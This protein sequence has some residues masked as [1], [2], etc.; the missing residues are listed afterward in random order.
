MIRR[1][2]SARSGRATTYSETGPYLPATMLSIRELFLKVKLDPQMA[3]EDWRKL[4]E[5]SRFRQAVGQIVRMVRGERVGINMMDIAVCGAIAPYN[6]L[7]GGKL[8]CLL[9]CGP[10][11]IKE[12]RARYG[13][14]TSLIASCMRGASVKRVADLVLLCTTSLYGSALSQYSR[15][16]VPTAL[17]GGKPG[18]KVEFDCVGLSEGFG[19]FHFSKD[20]LRMMGMLL[21][22]S[23]EARKVNSIFGEGVNPLMRKIREG[24]G[25]LGLPADVLLKHGSKRVVYG[26]A[27]ARNFQ[28]YLLGMSD[29]PRYLIP[30]TRE[31]HRTALLA[32]YW[33]QRWLLKRIEKPGVLDEVARHTCVYPIRH[34]AQVE[35]PPEGEEQLDLWTPLDS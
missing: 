3:A 34:G 1:A 27:L 25:L 9:L 10:E 33:R 8:V 4:F 17:L 16:K 12:Y 2:V 31:K 14:Q 35:L 30:Q 20:S 19:S 23:K 26:V 18:E 13:Q 32:D 5:S 15:V 6:L 11:V 7:L 28:E 22:R 24:L 21:G 29:S